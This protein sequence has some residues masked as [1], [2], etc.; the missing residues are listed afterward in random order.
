MFSTTLSLTLPRLDTV[1]I[2]TDWEEYE[3]QV[4]KIE[5][6]RIQFVAPLPTENF[7]GDSVIGDSIAQGTTIES[8][9]TRSIT[10]SKVPVSAEA[11]PVNFWHTQKTLRSTFPSM[12]RRIK[13]NTIRQI[14][15][16]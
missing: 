9:A 12:G 14:D 13:R 5:G 7:E 6:K 10:L 2:E 1:A 15:E 3:L 16:R 8:V 11:N 4:Q